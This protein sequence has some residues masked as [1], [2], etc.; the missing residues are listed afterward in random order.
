MA[1]LFLNWIY[2]RLFKPMVPWQGW[3][4]LY[5][6]SNIRAM[7]RERE[8]LPHKCAWT[9]SN[10]I[11][12]IFLHQREKS[13]NHT[14]SDRVYD[15]IKQ[16]DLALSSKSQ[17]V[18]HSRIPVFSTECSGIHGIKKKTDSS[19]WLLHSQVFEEISQ[20]LGSSKIDLFPSHLY[21]PADLW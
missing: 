12:S 13:E 15:Q 17:Y 7:V 5:G 19:E 20:Q 10:K 21:R 6:S 18:Y 2:K 8:S 16:T 3:S 11:D 1:A 4:S 9:T 14:L